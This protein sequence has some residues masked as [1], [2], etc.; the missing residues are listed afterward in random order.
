MNSS[1]SFGQL[2][3][4]HIS[5]AQ[6][7]FLRFLVNDIAGDGSPGP[8]LIGEVSYKSYSPRKE[9]YLT[10][11]TGRN[12]FS[13]HRG[14]KCEK[15]L[16]DFHMKSITSSRLF[17]YLFIYSLL[18]HI[19]YGK[20]NTAGLQFKCFLTDNPPSP[21]HRGPRPLLFSNSSVGSFTSHKNQISESTV[22]RDLRFLVLI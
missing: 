2:G 3:S 6:G 20:H 21:A 4:S 17:I 7:H 22:R 13:S 19:R 14:V 16:A 12:I 8:V 18:P 5:L 10:R 15:S 9:I 1:L 11:T